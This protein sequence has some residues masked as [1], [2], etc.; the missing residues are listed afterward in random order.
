MNVE[1]Q[2]KTKVHPMVE[3]EWFH[4]RNNSGCVFDPD[5]PAFF[6][7][8]RDG[9]EMFAGRSG[10]VTTARIIS[11][12]PATEDVLTKFATELSLPDVYGEDFTDFP[13]VSSYLEYP[14]MRRMLEDNGYDS[15]VGEDGYL[16][17]AVVWD[18]SRIEIIS[19]DPFND[20]TITP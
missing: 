14:E 15:Y 3:G 4:G 9:V 16:Y 17:V 13:D 2:P 19:T 8:E 18:P 5:R 10:M 6:A 20:N 11:H 1:Q 7:H 12:R